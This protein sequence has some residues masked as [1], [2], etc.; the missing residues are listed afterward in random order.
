MSSLSPAKG[1]F[2]PSVKFLVGGVETTEYDPRTLYQGKLQGQWG[3]VESGHLLEII[4]YEDK[5]A[6]VVIQRTRPGYYYLVFYLINSVW[7]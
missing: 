1:L 4:C 3:L 5:K 2:G 7:E 6:I